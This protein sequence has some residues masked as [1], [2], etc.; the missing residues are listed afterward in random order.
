MVDYSL[1]SM[2]QYTWA[3]PMMQYGELWKNGRKLLHEFFNPRAVTEYDEHQRKHAH[4]LL[5]RLGESPEHFLD[6]AEL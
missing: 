6:H 1:L 5:L 2:G 3:I 4:R